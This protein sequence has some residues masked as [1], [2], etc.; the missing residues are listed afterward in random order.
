MYRF[1]GLP[2][3]GAR[4]QSLSSSTRMVDLQCIQKH[5]TRT[6]H[7]CDKKLL[8]LNHAESMG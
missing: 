6:T 3:G 2:V 8:L 4:K 5:F 1:L 7:I